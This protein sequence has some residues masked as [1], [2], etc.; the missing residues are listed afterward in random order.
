MLA[1]RRAHTTLPAADMDRA[2]RWYEEM[3]GFTPYEVLRLITH[4]P[5]EESGI[6]G[7]GGTPPQMS[8]DGT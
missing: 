1:Q 5:L 3:L 2:T 4:D 6:S 7:K 8:A